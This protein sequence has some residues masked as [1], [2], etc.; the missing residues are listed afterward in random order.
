MA[1]EP[2]VAIEYLS[3]ILRAIEKAQNDPAEMR[4]LVY[5]VA[6]FNLGTQVLTR[7]N[8]I[9]SAE[10]RRYVLDLE[11]AI[12]E[13]ERLWR[14]EHQLPSDRSDL[15][16]L[17][18]AI[19]P[20]DHSAV[21]VRD[22]RS[23]AKTDDGFL[24]GEVI[25]VHDAPMDFYRETA[26]LSQF[27]Q[28]IEV[29]KPTLGSGQK[30]KW[31]ARWPLLGL[32]TV[33]ML[34]II[35]YVGVAMYS[36]ISMRL[37]NSQRPDFNYADK[38]FQSATT[39]PMAPN[40]DAGRLTARALLARGNPGGPALDFP[41]PTAYGVYAVSEGKLFEISAL[42]MK[43]PDSRV[44]ISAIISSPSPVTIPNGKLTFIIFR[45]DLLSSAPD[46]VALRVVAR[47]VREMRYSGAGPPT[48]TKINDQWAIRSKSYALRVA[49]VTDNPEMIVLRPQDALSALSPG[50]YALV[51]GGHGYDFSIDGQM[52][53]T[54]Q[55]LE[56]TNA[57]GGMV[58]SEC[59]N[60]P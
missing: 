39:S 22:P 59:G 50:R 1:G 31:A 17:G 51:Y 19:S 21:T 10:F 23:D 7:H 29:W 34:S 5:D 45:R 25:V 37:E 38:L 42:A 40:A 26:A 30:G 28:P 43:V 35:A 32:A 60:L 3:I 15:R 52:T 6:R 27:F 57:I 9:D 8:D 20:S 36:I 41:L 4:G 12:R 11:V 55:C 14:Q 46:E 54:A 49:P 44:A 48:S 16:L 58:Y 2:S 24:K 18:S 53:D 56:R 47:V 13:A 33:M